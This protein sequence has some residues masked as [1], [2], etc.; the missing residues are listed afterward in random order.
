M[1]ELSIHPGV[2]LLDDCPARGI[3]PQA[4]EERLTGRTPA[5][6]RWDGT[7]GQSFPFG[8]GADG[9]TPSLCPAR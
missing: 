6:A 2:S 8:G 7:L 3:L 9:Q 1:S 5:G 4:G